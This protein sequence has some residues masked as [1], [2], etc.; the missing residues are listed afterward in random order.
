MIKAAVIG[1]PIAHSLSPKIHN[2]FLEKY[3]IAGSYEAILVS[4]NDLENEVSN[5]VNQGFAGFN[6]TIPH[7]E[8]IFKL[9]HYKSKSASLSGAVNTVVIT[10]DG[11]LFGH[12]S[13]IDGFLNNLKNHAPEFNLKDKTAFVIGAGGAVRAIVYGLLKSGVKKIYITNRNAQKA[14]NL[15]DNFAQFKT[16]ISFCEMPEFCQ[17]LNECDLLINSTSLGMQGQEKLNID[18]SKLN[19]NSIVYDIIYKPLMT[20]LLL[21]AQK[22]GNNIVTGIGM[23]V[24]QALI[25]FELWFKQKPISEKK[26]EEILLKNL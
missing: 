6:I 24:E 20:D 22:R 15:I 8:S 21:A 10:E 5:L 11:K 25:G 18:L 14:Q 9:C 7:K 4:K 13:D 23:L 26:L 2:F 1:D 3:K 12:N 17:K 19:K 16:E